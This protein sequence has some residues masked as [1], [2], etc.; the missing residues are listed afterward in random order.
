MPLNKSTLDKSPQDPST[1]IDNLMK[2]QVQLCKAKTKIITFSES[3]I[4]GITKNCR[5]ANA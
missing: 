4:R 2:C 5:N 1:K 3:E